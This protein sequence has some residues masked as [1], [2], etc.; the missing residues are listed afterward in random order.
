MNGKTESGRI[1]GNCI[2]ENSYFHGKATCSKEIWFGLWHAQAVNDIKDARDKAIQYEK[3][4]FGDVTGLT[5]GDAFRHSIWNTLIAKYYAERKKDVLK[6]VEMALEFTNLHEE[7]N[8]VCGSDD[9]DI[10]MDKHNNFVGRNYFLSTAFIQTTGK[11]PFRKKHLNSLTDN[12]YKNGTKAKADNALKLPKSK[13]AVESSYP[14]T[15]VYF[16]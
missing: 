1:I 7:C 11:W 10:A 14:Y 3:D 6:G 5:V 15:L 8:E 9:W 16:Q 13:S 12:Q 2:D 4:L